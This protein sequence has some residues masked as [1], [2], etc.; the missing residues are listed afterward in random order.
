MYN[1]LHYNKMNHYIIYNITHNELN[2]Y[3]PS[4]IL[5]SRALVI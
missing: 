1:V 3:N 4:F 5:Y 2:N